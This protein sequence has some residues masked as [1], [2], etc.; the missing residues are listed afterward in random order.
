MVRIFLYSDWIHENTDQKKT[1]YLDIFH[2]VGVALYITSFSK[3]LSFFV[4]ESSAQFRPFDDDFP[5]LFCH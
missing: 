1:P 3:N 5:E 4:Y 2:V